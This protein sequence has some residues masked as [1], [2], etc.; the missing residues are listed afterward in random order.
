LRVTGRFRSPDA[1]LYLQAFSSMLG[2]CVV[3]H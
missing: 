1:P 2:N 3:V